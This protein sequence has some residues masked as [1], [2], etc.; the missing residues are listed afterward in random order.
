MSRSTGRPF[1]YRST[2]SLVCPTSLYRRLLT[3]KVQRML[4]ATMEVA[5]TTAR[6][7]MK[8]QSKA[9]SFA[10]MAFSIFWISILSSR[11]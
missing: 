7:T 10:F 8:I 5:D 2:T 3:S 4:P 9:L 6:S 11:S 1:H